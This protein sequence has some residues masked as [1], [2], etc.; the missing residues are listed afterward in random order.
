MKKILVCFSLKYVRELFGRYCH[1][2]ELLSAHGYCALKH[3]LVAE[4]GCNRR[5]LVRLCI[6][7][8]ELPPLILLT[9]LFYCINL[10]SVT[11]TDAVTCVTSIRLCIT[12]PGREVTVRIVVTSQPEL[13]VRNVNLTT[14]DKIRETC[15]IR[16]TVTIPV[17]TMTMTNVHVLW[18]YSVHSQVP[19]RLLK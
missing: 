3:A 2:R 9:Q 6:N 14:S 7:C 4:C 13:N 16:V 18:I 1:V 10:Q 12:W 17:C 8:Y 5:H 15:V 11:V 19:R